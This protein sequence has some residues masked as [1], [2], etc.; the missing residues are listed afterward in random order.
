M[1]SPEPSPA[2]APGAGRRAGGAR[3]LSIQRFE[4][5]LQQLRTQIRQLE[6]DQKIVERQ[7]RAALDIGEQY[8][9]V[10]PTEDEMISALVRRNDRY[11]EAVD[12]MLAEV[13]R[14]TSFPDQPVGSLEQPGDLIGCPTYDGLIARTARRTAAKPGTEASRVW[15]KVQIDL[16]RILDEPRI[17]GAL[18]CHPRGRDRRVGLAR[19]GE[20]A[21]R[22][23]ALRGRQR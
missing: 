2:Q 20:R 5:K 6:R 21:G 3:R 11:A 9:S 16:G 22:R 14:L 12:R 18:T 10:V 8:L 15:S 4:A 13:N 1:P 23:G 7:R 19:A 17:A